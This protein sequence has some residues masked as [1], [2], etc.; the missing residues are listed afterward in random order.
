[1]KMI[2][3]KKS[4]VGLMMA[5]VALAIAGFAYSNVGTNSTHL[6]TVQLKTLESLTKDENKESGCQWEVFK[7]KY[8][9]IRHICV[10]G[11]NGYDCQCGEVS[12]D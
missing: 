9:C 2:K 12:M 3:P 6:S 5:T 8:G 1:M 4:S 11:G 10:M 7:D